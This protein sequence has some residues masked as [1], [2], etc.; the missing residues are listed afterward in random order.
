MD[1]KHEKYKTPLREE[2]GHGVTDKA[3]DIL[4]KNDIKTVGKLMDL[5]ERIGEREYFEKMLA[6]MGLKGENPQRIG[7]FCASFEYSLQTNRE[8][9]LVY[10]KR[11][12]R[13]EP[14]GIC[15]PDMWLSDGIWLI[16]SNKNTGSI[17]S[18]CNLNGVVDDYGIIKLSSNPVLDFEKVAKMEYY[19]DAVVAVMRSIPSGSSLRQIACK[20]VAA[21]VE[22]TEQARHDTKKQG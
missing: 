5:W 2:V 9:N 17:R 8:H 3:F 13:Y 7:N 19:T 21:M 18:V 10:K 14:I 20:V 4:E 22:V 1:K 16:Q 11:N 15:A 12:G 6:G